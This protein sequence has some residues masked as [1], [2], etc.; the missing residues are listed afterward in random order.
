VIGI[1]VA[2]GLTRLT[3]F[4]GMGSQQEGVA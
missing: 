1:A 2:L 3:G 4:T